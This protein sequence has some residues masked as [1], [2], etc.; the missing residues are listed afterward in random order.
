MWDSEDDVD[1]EGSDA[2]R[3]TSLWCSVLPEEEVMQ[4][5]SWRMDRTDSTATAEDEVD[6][7]WRRA[8]LVLYTG[9]YPTPLS[10]SPSPLPISTKK[11]LIF[12]VSQRV[13]QRLTVKCLL[14]ATDKLRRVA[15]EGH[16][17]QQVVF[18][19]VVLAWLLG[20]ESDEEEYCLI[21][22][23]LRSRLKALSNGLAKELEDTL[24]LQDPAAEA[25]IQENINAH[26]RGKYHSVLRQSI[27]SVKGFFKKKPQ[28][29]EGDEASVGSEHL[30]APSE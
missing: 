22:A 19:Q 29:E 21:R 27:T 8:L 28:P 9:K 11:N 17:A 26:L 20:V 1:F 10:P 13:P 5:V 2:A 4:V 12:S 6:E 18:L 16:A 30:R 25:Q 3:L 7:M 24:R 14:K 15:G 23:L